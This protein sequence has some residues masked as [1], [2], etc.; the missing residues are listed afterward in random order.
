LKTYM[1]MLGMRAEHGMRW[2]V[3]MLVGLVVALIPTALWGEDAATDGPAP[4]AFVL[5]VQAQRLSLQAR[6]ASLHAILAQIGW[7]LGVDVVVHLPEDEII[8]VTFEQLPLG[9]ALKKL[10]PNYAYVVDTAR[11]DRRLRK[12][13]VFPKGETPTSQSPSPPATAPPTAAQRP[14]PFQF[15]FDPSK[16]M[17]EGK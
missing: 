14:P 1:E 4:P 5:T 15:E 8:T 6:E 16:A 11:G 2:R 12:I 17:Q 9:E 3:M 7:E 10:S 13:M